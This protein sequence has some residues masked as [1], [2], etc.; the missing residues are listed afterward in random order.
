M[1][2]TGLEQVVILEYADSADVLGG[3]PMALL[4]ITPEGMQG[5]GIAIGNALEGVDQYQP[6]LQV[7][8]TTHVGMTGVRLAAAK[9]GGA[10][11]A[12]GGGDHDGEATAEWL[13]TTRH[14]TRRQDERRAAHPV[15]PDRLAGPGLRGHRPDRAA[16]DRPD[17][18]D[19]G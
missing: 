10:V 7:G 16:G 15:R 12:F 1:L 11:G 5:A 4:H 6:V 8:D 3:Q 19:R 14:R 2:G 17:A 13:E 18:V 9:D